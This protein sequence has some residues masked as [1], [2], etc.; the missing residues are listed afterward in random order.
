VPEKDVTILNISV[1][2]AVKMIISGGIIG[3]EG[4]HLLTETPPVQ[5]VREEFIY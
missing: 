4:R 3:P 1:D 2:E 5:L